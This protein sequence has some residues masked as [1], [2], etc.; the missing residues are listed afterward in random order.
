MC[1]QILQPNL[2][3]RDVV[4]VDENILATMEQITLKPK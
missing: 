1:L 2:V 4:H 3:D